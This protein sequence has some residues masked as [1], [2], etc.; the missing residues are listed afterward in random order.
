M[1]FLSRR[2]LRKLNFSFLGENVLIS[3]KCSIYSPSSLRIGDNS[4]IDDFCVLSGN[5]SIGR[6]V[7]IAVFSNLAAGN[8]SITLHDFVGLAFGCHV[9]AQSDD[10][11]GS[12][13][14][15]PTV[16]SKFKKETSQA[17]SI[18]RHTILGAG[19]IVLPGVSIPEGV[20]SGANTLFRGNP[21]PWSIYVG[22]P[23]RRIKERSQD[24]LNLETDYLKE[25]S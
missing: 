5:I 20:S 4:R 24:L 8:S 9:I 17:I 23:A 2:Q 3:D 7:H 22:S 16:P 21:E 12:T 19:S 10:Y 25:Q 6:N 11:S 13:M 1:G 15:N 18:G 14:T